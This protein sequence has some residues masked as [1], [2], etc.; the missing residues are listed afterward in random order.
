M[1]AVVGGGGLIQLPALLGSLPAHSTATL[2]G[3]NKLS[4]LAGTSIAA[5]RYI[6]AVKVQ[7]S[8][9]L[10]MMCIAGPASW[11]GAQLVSLV[12]RE[13]AQ[14]VILVVLIMVAVFTFRRKDF[15]LHQTRPTRGVMSLVFVGISVAALLGF[16][17]GALG[18]GTGAFLM[19]FFVRFFGYDFVH[20]SAA[21]KAIN[22]TT[23]MTALLFFLPMG[24]VIWGLGLMM[25]L[26]NVVGAYWG[27]R[28]AVARGSR[29]VRRLF[30]FVLCFMIARMAWVTWESLF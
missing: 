27:T 6:R 16:Y 26:C 18:P 14:P 30:L 17:D 28:M 2:L 9:L 22:W 1:D 29:F 13:Q 15:G 19:F 11:W 4:S 3:T 24:Q 7:W 25:A 12:P 23:N 5:W 20:A 21:S 8:V 10:P